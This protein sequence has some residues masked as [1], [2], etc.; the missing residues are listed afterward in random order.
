MFIDG[1]QPK[2]QEVWHRLVTLRNGQVL[3]DVTWADLHWNLDEFPDETRGEM[4]QSGIGDQVRI[5]ITCHGTDR[6]SVVD[7]VDRKVNEIL[8]GEQ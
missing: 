3:H 2:R 4:R 8:R 6:Q 1:E 5:D 7:K